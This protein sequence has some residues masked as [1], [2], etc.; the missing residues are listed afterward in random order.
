[1]PRQELSKKI[2]DALAEGEKRD[3]DVDVD[4]PLDGID[5]DELGDD[6]PSDDEIGDDTEDADE[7]A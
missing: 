1:M 7:S 5:F 4:E 2:G 6:D 3:V